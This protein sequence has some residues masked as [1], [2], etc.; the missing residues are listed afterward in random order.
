MAFFINAGLPR[1]FQDT[2]RLLIQAGNQRKR[3]F[4][5]AELALFIPDIPDSHKYRKNAK[6]QNLLSGVDY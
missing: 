3:L 5:V 1:C 4:L 2:T 6:N